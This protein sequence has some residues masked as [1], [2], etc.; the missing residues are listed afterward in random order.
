MGQIRAFGWVTLAASP[1][2]CTVGALLSRSA[3]AWVAETAVGRPADPRVAWPIHDLVR[4][5][6]TS[7]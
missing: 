7:R 5:V 3:S 4:D 2:T 6:T 1:D